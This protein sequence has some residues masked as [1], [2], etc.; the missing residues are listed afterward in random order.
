M[1]KSILESEALSVTQGP[2]LSATSDMP[3]VDAAKIV[4]VAP[5]P[6]LT[7]GDTKLVADPQMEE[8]TKVIETEVPVV[9]EKKVDETPAWMKAEVT[10][11]RNR[12]READEGRT[13][14][15]TR[16]VAAEK[17]AADA[18]AALKALTEPKIQV[19]AKP[20]PVRDT[21]DSPEAYDAALIEYASE[22]AAAELQAKSDKQRADADREAA[23]KTASDTATAAAAA[24]KT[25]FESTMTKFNERVM[26]LATDMPDFSE[27]VQSDDLLITPEMA[28]VI[29]PSE[30]GPRM[31]YY[32]GKH[33]DEAARIAA[34][35][36]VQQ[37]F[38]MGRIH[39]GLPKIKLVS[40][41]PAPITP[42]GSRSD[43]TKTP[44]MET[45]DEYADR[46]N[47]EI[48]KQRK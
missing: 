18:A 40:T 32:L 28:S 8:P 24:Q 11:E 37:I 31:A 14:A 16:A 47:T 12:R 7:P 25:Q 45:M 23:E 27:V 13:A 34:L 2:A 3:V 44:Q 46:R 41:A 35:P 10:K 5:E 33:P 1:S 43:A 21:F 6:T 29:L 30:E 22:K 39:A 15:E 4:K 42:L 36:P 26:S 17:L 48:R 9:A 19:E 20:R 38:E